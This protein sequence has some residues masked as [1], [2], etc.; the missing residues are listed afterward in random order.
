VRRRRSHARPRRHVCAAS[1][2][3]PPRCTTTASF[4]ARASAALSSRGAS[5]ALF[6]QRFGSRLV[7]R[8]LGRRLVARRATGDAGPRRAGPRPRFSW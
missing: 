6:V 2:G 4:V 8:R 1:D 3:G 5:A 7:A